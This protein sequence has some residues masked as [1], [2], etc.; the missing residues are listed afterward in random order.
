MVSCV[1][2]NHPCHCHNDET[3]N[4]CDCAYCEHGNA[5]DEFWKNLKDGTHIQE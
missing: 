5:L 3:C 4:K 2:C 1:N